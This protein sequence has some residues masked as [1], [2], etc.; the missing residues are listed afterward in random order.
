MDVKFADL[1]TLAG[2][3]IGVSDWLLIDQSRIDAF[4][5]ATGNQQGIHGEAKASPF[6]GTMADSF[7]TLSLIT[8]LAADL[9]T[10]RGVVHSINYGTEKVRFL[11]MVPVGK[12]VRLRQKVLAVEPRSGGLL[13]RHEM[14]IELEGSETPACVAETLNLVFGV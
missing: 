2:R 12:C 7:L 13:L 3:E 11:A 8:S 1:P 6:G 5:K 4:A 14:T 9:L 10:I